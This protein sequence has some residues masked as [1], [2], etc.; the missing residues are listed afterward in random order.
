MPPIIHH[1]KLILT[2]GK[3]V[4][5]NV[6]PSADSRNLDLTQLTWSHYGR[7]V[8]LTSEELEI[9]KMVWMW[10]PWVKKLMRKD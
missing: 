9:Y 8:A 2:T 4:I 7:L 3:G 6:D 10:M 5:R 1:I